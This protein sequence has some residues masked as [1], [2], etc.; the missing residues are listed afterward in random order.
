MIRIFRRIRLAMSSSAIRGDFHS[1]LC[2]AARVR[3]C[4]SVI[5]A[6]EK[7]EYFKRMKGGYP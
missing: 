1:A 2:V 3:Q 6:H 4:W 5:L 7:A